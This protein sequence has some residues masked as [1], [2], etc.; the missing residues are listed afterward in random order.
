MG[1]IFGDPSIA[2]IAL[3]DQRPLALIVIG[4]VRRRVGQAP[5][6]AISAVQVGIT[7][8]GRNPTKPC[9]SSRR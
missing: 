5:A 6:E 8:A 1:Q 3:P 4:I 9:R 2:V 7:V